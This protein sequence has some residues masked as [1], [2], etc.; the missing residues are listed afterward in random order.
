MGPT[1][2]L[3]ARA[4]LLAKACSFNAC[5]EVGLHLPELGQVEGGDL[6]GLLNLLLVG[7]DLLLKV[8]EQALHIFVV[9]SVLV[10]SILELLDVSL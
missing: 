2:M 4:G 8:V 1:D 3:R 10:L 5:P 9:L 7:L 6:F